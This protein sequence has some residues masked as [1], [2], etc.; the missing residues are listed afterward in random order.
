MIYGYGSSEEH[1]P[2]LYFRGYPVYAA[3]FL[4]ALLVTSMIATSLLMGFDMTAPVGWLDFTVPQVLAGQV[5]RVFTY[6]L[7]N[8][9]TL[10]FAIDMAML[11]WFGREVEKVLGR[12]RFFGL[13]IGIYM[14]APIVSLLGARWW[15]GALAGETGTLAV[16]VAFAT[17]YPDVPIFFNVLAR[18]MAVILVGIFSL[19]AVAYHNPRELFILWVSTGFAYLFVRHELGHFSLPVMRLPRRRAAAPSGANRP[20]GAGAREKALGAASMA[21]VDALLDKIAQ[22][23]FSSLTA[24][25]RARLDSARTEINKRSSGRS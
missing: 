5:W 13:Y 17:F 12:R 7:V 9:P 23:G 25:E 20:A 8:Q 11:A 18:W 3:H 16:F 22:S 4:V 24:A 21:E 1:R 19:S 10:N 6:G 14:V 15:P 2:L